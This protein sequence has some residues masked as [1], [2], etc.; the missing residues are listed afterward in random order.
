METHRTQTTMSGDSLD[1]K[2][3]NRS[4]LIVRTNYRMVLY[5]QVVYKYSNYLAI[6]EY[7]KG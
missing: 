4:S 3:A 6:I 5:H 1:N 7:T 2:T